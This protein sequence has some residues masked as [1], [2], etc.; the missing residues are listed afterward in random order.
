MPRY[1]IDR[2]FSDGLHIPVDERHQG[3]RCGADKN[4]KYAVTWARS[5]ATPDKTNTSRIHDTPSYLT[6][7]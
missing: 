4:T 1:L 6:P 3:L 7:I 5:N 2:S